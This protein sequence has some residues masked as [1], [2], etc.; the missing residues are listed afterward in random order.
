MF[1]F[2]ISLNKNIQL[3]YFSIVIF[4]FLKNISLLQISHYLQ[5]IRIMSQPSI[6]LYIYNI[7]HLYLITYF[8]LSYVLITR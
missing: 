6:C 5:I 8:L 2:T 4:S 1:A 7:Y 3:F